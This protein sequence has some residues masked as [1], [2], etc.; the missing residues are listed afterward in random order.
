M[1]EI[2]FD[3]D[4]E[5]ITA[6][7]LRKDGLAVILVLHERGGARKLTLQVATEI[8]GDMAEELGKLYGAAH[9][10]AILP[11][12]DL[13]PDRSYRPTPE[14]HLIDAGA[15]IYHPNDSSASLQVRTKDGRDLLLM[16]DPDAFQELV[17][18][19]E[20]RDRAIPPSEM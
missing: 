7:A 5:T 13:E 19:A 3:F 8:V 20:T 2:N 12:R 15:L 18:D 1:R 17:R 16:F 11:S 14:T 4:V 10:Q 9:I 6:P